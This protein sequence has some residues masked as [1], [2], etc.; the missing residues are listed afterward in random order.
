MTRAKIDFGIDLGTT[1]SAIAVMNGGDIKIIKSL[2]WERDTTSSAVSF[3]RK[4]QVRAGD[5]GLL[6]YRNELASNSSGTEQNGFVEF[7]RTMGTDKKYFSSNMKRSYSSEELSAEILKLLRSSVKDEDVHAAVVTVPNQF[8]QNQIDATQRAAEL[9]G[10]KCCELLQEPIAASMAYGVQAESMQGYWVVFDFGGGT[11][12][13]ALMKVDEGIMKVV[14]T[15][16]DNHLGGKDIDI[17][18]VDRVILPKLQEEYSLDKL[19]SDPARSAKFRSII[20]NDGGEKIKIELSTASVSEWSPDEPIGEDDEGEDIDPEISVTLEEFEEAVSPIFAKAIS[21][22]KDLLSKN[23]LSK[24]DLDSI[25]LVGG[26]TMSQTLRRMLRDEFGDL[27]DT[28]VDP[29]TSVACGAALFAATRNIPEDQVVRDSAKVQ[30]S[31][32]YPETTVETEEHL[33]IKVDTGSTDGDV[34]DSLFAEISRSD[35]GWASGKVEISDGEIVD[36]VLVPGKTN[37][38]DIRLTDG[39]GDTVQSQPSSFIIIQGLTVANATLPHSICIDSL[40]IGTGKQR[41]VLLDGLERNTSL[42]AKGKGT[43]KTQKAIRPGNPDDI[44]KIPVIEGNPGERAIYNQP[45]GI[46]TC[47]GEDFS[48]F[49]PEGSEVE[50]TVT[51]DSSRRGKLEAYFPHIDETVEKILK[52]SHDTEQREYDADYLRSE[53][54][55]A[56]IALDLLSGPAVPSLSQELG[57]LAQQLDAAGNDYDTKLRVY[58]NLQKLLKE[59]DTIEEAEEWPDVRMRLEGAF[60]HLKTVNEQ[61]GNAETNSLVLQLQPNIQ[62]VIREQNIKLAN[63][64]IDQMSVLSF[65]LVRNETGLWISYVKG[66]DDDFD[67][68]DWTN[69]AEA[70]RL[71]NE[72]KSAIAT[73]PSREQIEGIVMQLFQLL[74]DKNTTVGGVDTNILTS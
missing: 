17:A 35:G 57:L 1:N 10:L 26:P 48:E 39:K 62:L 74:P 5:D 28:S 20:K 6:G 53:I 25:L 41:L 61:Y 4:Q 52:D 19:L 42:P 68:H 60:E 8:R 27:V 2:R 21:I 22:T 66:Y 45:A 69:R 58:E 7:K 50:I 24:N 49:L 14:D 23:N 63:D 72:A 18:L 29:M 70:R 71:I 67:S 30:L 32:K 3:T 44:L 15:G 34:P 33:G 54:K 64:L 55:K 59:L 43:F 40:L 47:S 37:T 51:F 16:G 65:S 56:Q 36:L 38:F 46:V 12:D 31:L 73:N 9:A 13:A 11:F